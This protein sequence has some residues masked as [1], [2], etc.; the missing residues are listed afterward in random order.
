MLTGEQRKIYDE[1]IE[2]VAQDRGGV[3]FLYAFAGT[4]KTFLWKVL[5]VAIISKGE[6]VLNTASSGIASLLL[7]GGRTTHSRFGI[8]INPNESTTCNMERG[9]DLAELVKEAKLIIW[10]EVSMMS[11]Y[12]FETLDRSFK[13][14]LPCPEGKLFGGKVIL[15]G[16]DFRQIL[17]VIVGAGREQIVSSSLNASYIWNDCKVLQLT[18]NMRLLQEIGV[19]EAREIE[20]FSKWIL[21]VG[22]GKLNEPNDGIAEIQIPEE[23]L[24]TEG[25]NPIESIIRA[26]YGDSFADS[27]DLTFFQEKAILCP[28]NDDVNSINEHM[29]SK[30]KGIFL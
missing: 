3:V 14:I 23:L 5:S 19:N 9:S 6:I 8:P 24:I 2:A 10:D 22:E 25:D 17:P 20:E 7:E 18:K 16:G 11:K 26:V 12:C 21:D 13:D 4:G 28:T 29:L 27:K 15:F 30:L 1:I